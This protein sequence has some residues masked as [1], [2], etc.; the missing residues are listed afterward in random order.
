MSKILRVFRRRTSHTPDDD[1]VAIGQPGLFPAPDCSEIHISVVFGWDVAWAHAAARQWRAVTGKRVRVGGPGVQGKNLR[2]IPPGEFT[3]GLYVR[4]GITYTTRGCP[5]HCPWCVV[6][7]TEGKLRCL[8]IKP[9]HR[10]QDNNLTAAPLGHFR[11]VCAMLR[12]Q[13]KGATFAGGLEA[14]RLT[15]DHLA[16]LAS[17]RI[18][19]VW[20]A[21]D[22][23]WTA[24]VATAI[25]N[26]RRFLPRE[27]VRCFVLIG[28]HP[29][30]T[31]QQAEGRL[32]TVWDAG[33]MPF[34]QL[35]RPPL[36][37]AR[38][39]WPQPWRDLA[40]TWSRPAAM[41]AATKEH[42]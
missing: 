6:P 28:H 15:E 13:P 12:E 27:K 23:G 18:R 17:M 32:K 1:M 39:R 24:E 37:T 7:S 33:A 22:S 4:E 31:L 40:R 35:Y 38:T 30:E 16:E 26:L 21:A 41:K 2:P 11:E 8:R 34:A 3:P 9:G 29:S 19:E 14:A 20:T 36:Q 25:E 5:N 10:V 42:A